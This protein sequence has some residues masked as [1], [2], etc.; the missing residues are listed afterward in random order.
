VLEALPVVDA[1]ALPL[2]GPSAV[3]AVLRPPHATPTM[4]AHAA[5]VDVVTPVAMCINMGRPLA[6]VN[7]GT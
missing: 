2:A 4:T 1:P 3:L 6:R 5:S 7:A